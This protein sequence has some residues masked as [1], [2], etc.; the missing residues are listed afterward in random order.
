MMN[1]A[2]LKSIQTSLR[3][4]YLSKTLGAKGEARDEYNQ[5]YYSTPH[6]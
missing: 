5:R 6:L 1:I 2:Y 3:I 4:G